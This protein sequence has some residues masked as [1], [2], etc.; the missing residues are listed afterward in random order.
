[1]TTSRVSLYHLM[2]N[3]QEIKILRVKI[4]ISCFI[5]PKEAF[6]ILF[7]SFTATFRLSLQLI[8]LFRVY[9]GSISGLDLRSSLFRDFRSLSGQII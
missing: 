1:M 4:S 3:E 9:L 2:K 7:N 5:Y 8:R 6:I